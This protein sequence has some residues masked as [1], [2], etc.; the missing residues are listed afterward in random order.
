MRPEYGG[1][2]IIAHFA[3]A[4]V[5]GA[6]RLVSLFPNVGDRESEVRRE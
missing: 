4:K 5:A 1:Y 2:R 3:V 6:S